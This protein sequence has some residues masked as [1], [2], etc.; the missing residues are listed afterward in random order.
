MTAVTDQ[1][2]NITTYEYSPAGRMTAKSYPNGVQTSYSYDGSSTLTGLNMSKAGELLKSYDIVHDERDK[3]TQITEDATQ[4][5]NYTYDDAARLVAEESPYIG[6]I[7][8]TYDS[9]GNLT[10]KLKQGEPST[11]YAYNDADQLSS[12]SSGN[13]YAYNSR[14][15][16]TT[17]TS[18]S[19]T[20]D[21]AWDGKGRL[22]SVVDTNGLSLSFIYDP[23]DRTY[24][25]MD[26]SVQTS[27]VYDLASDTEIAT[28][29]SSNDI[30]NLYLS[31]ADGLISDTNT[32]GTVYYSYDPLSDT[33]LITDSSGNVN[34][35]LHY[36]AWG[37]TMEE[38]S[39]PN[40]YL[41]KYQRR[42]YASA[43]LIKMGARYYDP[44][45]G[46]F[47]SR[48]PQNGKDEIVMSHNDYAYTY[49]D[50]VNQ[51][52][53]AGLSPFT[54]LPSLSIHQEI[55][56]RKMIILSLMSYH[57]VPFHMSG[58]HN[59]VCPGYNFDEHGRPCM[60]GS[61]G[62]IVDWIEDR[63]WKTDS[64]YRHYYNMMNSSY[65]DRKFNHIGVANIIKNGW[66]HPKCFD[67]SGLTGTA[68]REA[69]TAI[70]KPMYV[71]GTADQLQ[72]YCW[73]RRYLPRDA[74]PGDWAFGNWSSTK[75]QWQHSATYL[76]GSNHSVIET[77]GTGAWVLRATRYSH[78]AIKHHWNH[79]DDT[80]AGPRDTLQIFRPSAFSRVTTLEYA[81]NRQP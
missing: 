34:S 9:A 23:L 66:K 81:W 42:D 8:Y 54:K 5:T 30:N 57:D 74:L 16:L 45:T 28:V 19:G 70:K 26:S 72:N 12:D 55:K 10:S 32:E 59:G 17:I 67:C 35:Q 43:N 61:F 29:D 78:V 56:A 47:I 80:D 3:I 38:I 24:S 58:G 18:G 73:P 37:N 25:S 71:N 65:R 64:Q 44:N 2:D 20:R 11:S 15:D 53:I 33:S 36:D 13:I 46:R 21:Y 14:G 49:S 22:L 76:G 75:Q 79:A 6:N 69:M 41:G 63:S 27:F 62:E 48:D 31:G 52:D 7:T 77:P 39:E 51:N 4:V 40:N 50:P 68:F 60:Y 1:G